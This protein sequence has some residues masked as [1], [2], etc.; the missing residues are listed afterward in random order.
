MLCHPSPSPSPFATHLISCLVSTTTRQL[1]LP[2]S[3]YVTDIADTFLPRSFSLSL[4]H[5]LDPLPTTTPLLLPT[6]SLS[7]H[8]HSIYHENHKGS[9]PSTISTTTCLILPY[10]PDR[11]R[12]LPSSHSLSRVSNRS[13]LWHRQ[14]AWMGGTILLLHLSS[15]LVPYSLAPRSKSKQNQKKSNTY[16]PKT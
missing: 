14:T 11:S 4:A 16:T 1:E 6:L 15:P 9:L 5:S 7:L 10:R 3:R 2:G 13:F 8:N 12:S